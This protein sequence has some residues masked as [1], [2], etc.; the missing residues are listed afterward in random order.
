MLQLQTS[1]DLTSIE[2]NQ[3]YNNILRVVSHPAFQSQ[4]ANELSQ[5]VQEHAQ[6]IIL[7]SWMSF[8]IMVTLV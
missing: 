7:E 6:R 3:L 4:C 2:R 5:Y 8:G 1:D